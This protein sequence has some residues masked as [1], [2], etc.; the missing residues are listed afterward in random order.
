MLFTARSSSPVDWRHAERWQ[1][2]N[3]L[4]GV[5][6][7][8]AVLGHGGWDNSDTEERLVHAVVLD[9]DDQDVELLYIG[10]GTCRLVTPTC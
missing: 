2:R 10:A 7:R 4:S 8:Q 6:K 3:V 9:D 1:T 5:V